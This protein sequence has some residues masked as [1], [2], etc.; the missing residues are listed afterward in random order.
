METKNETARCASGGGER[1]ADDDAGS[2]GSET[3]GARKQFGEREAAEGKEKGR[4]L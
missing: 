2:E 1:T 3:S 4:G